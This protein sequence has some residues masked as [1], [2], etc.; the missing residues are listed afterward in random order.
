MHM[1]EQSPQSEF[2]DIPS[3]D[4]LAH[5]KARHDS[6]SPDKQVT[7]LETLAR[8]DNVRAAATYA[9]LSWESAYKLRGRPDG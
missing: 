5:S 1:T 3:A 2:T 4:D 7:F 8:T 6:W 9:G